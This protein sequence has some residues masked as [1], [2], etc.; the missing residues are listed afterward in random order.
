MGPLF[1][2]SSKGFSDIIS[3]ILMIIL[4]HTWHQRVKWFS[5][6]PL[7]AESGL[8][9]R[10][11]DLSLHHA[12]SGSRPS[13]RKETLPSVLELFETSAGEPGA[14]WGWGGGGKGSSLF[15]YSS[16]VQLIVYELIII[17]AWVIH[18]LEESDNE[19]ETSM[20]ASVHYGGD[21]GSL[22]S[23]QASVGAV[24]Q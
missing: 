14:G 17:W 15:P 4:W 16:L 7:V 19:S 23:L 24:L 6:N 18:P 11:P 9:L 21:I 22:G 5:H 2:R 8:W 3:F 12:T 1:P 13:W 10:S 20:D